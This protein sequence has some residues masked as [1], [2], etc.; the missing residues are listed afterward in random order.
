M[1]LGIFAYHC[2]CSL[3]KYLFR[4]FVFDVSNFKM[5]EFIFYFMYMIVLPECE[6]FVSMLGADE[7]R[8]KLQN[9]LN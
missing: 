7:V 4:S 3:E 2:M 5:Y 1:K 8:K 9:P 6:C